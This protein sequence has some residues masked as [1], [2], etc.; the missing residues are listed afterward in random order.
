MSVTHDT[1]Q[2]SHSA[3]ARHD[4]RQNERT[5]FVTEKAGSP[6]Q[7]VL[8]I[9]G[10]MLLISGLLL[11]W[12]VSKVV[13]LLFAGL[14]LAILLRIPTDWLSERTRLPGPAAL[15]VVLLAVLALL[16]AAGIYVAPAIDAQLDA[17]AQ[18]LPQGV[19]QLRDQ[20]QRY[21]WVQQLSGTIPSLQQMLPQPG[22]MLAQIGGVFSGILSVSVNMLVVVVVGFFLAFQPKMY[23]E[24]VIRMFSRPQRERTR[25]VLLAVGYS[26]RWWLLS[27]LFSMTVIGIATGIGLWLLDVPFVL[28][29]AVVSGLFNFIPF[30]GSY[31]ALIP[32]AL[33]ALMQSPMTLVYVLILYVAVQMVE[34]YFLTP[35]VQQ[36]AVDIP[37]VLAITV[38]LLM[39]VLVGLLGFVLAVPLTA[40]GLVMVKL[41]YIEGVLGDTA[42]VP[43]IRGQ[44]S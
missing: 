33:V 39:T 35:M 9:G 1:A 2:T 18:M 5:E 22:A 12:Y 34:S 20:F 23:L 16:G 29:L 8:G 28:T 38:Q 37:P 10:T 44:G 15:V 32:V 6:R 42:D 41:L 31:L 21:A 3:P 30:V 13:L 7:I 27:R 11:L 4:D 36:Q 19:N 43:H 26:L 14:L 24:G 17:L 40:V 25:E